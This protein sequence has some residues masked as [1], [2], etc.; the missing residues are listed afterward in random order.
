MNF[1][2]TFFLLTE[3]R[4][5]AALVKLLGIMSLRNNALNGIKT[6]KSKNILEM[7]DIM[8]QYNINEWKTPE[9]EWS[10]ILYFL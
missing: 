6:F 1:S 2:T 9:S 4:H 3:F 7:F 5:L 8:S 10:Y